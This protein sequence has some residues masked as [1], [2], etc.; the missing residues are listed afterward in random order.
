MKTIVHGC[1][2]FGPV[3][4]INR[5][6]MHCVQR[7]AERFGQKGTVGATLLW[8]EQ[9]FQQAM[10][11]QLPPEFHLTKLLKHDFKEARYFSFAKIGRQK[12]IIFVVVDGMIQTIHSGAAP[13]FK[14]ATLKP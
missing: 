2:P 14:Q 9:H 3:Q 4:G 6:S 12:S 10:E 11:V 1:A 13:E 8:L 5:V 7:A